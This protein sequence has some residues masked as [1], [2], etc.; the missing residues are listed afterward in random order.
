MTFTSIKA[1]KLMQGS[2]LKADLLD[3]GEEPIE[4]QADMLGGLASSGKS[5]VEAS[6]E[7]KSLERNPKE[8][9]LNSS[10]SIAKSRDFDRRDSEKSKQ[11]APQEDELELSGDEPESPFDELE[12]IHERKMRSQREAGEN[13]GS[14]A[15]NYRTDT[16]EEA[17]IGGSRVIPAETIRV[18]NRERE[19]ESKTR[20]AREF[21]NNVTSRRPIDLGEKGREAFKRKNLPSRKKR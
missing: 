13:G 17:K 18:E 10:R 15:E 7:E 12:K 4:E 21:E 2:K 20:T 16:G 14:W 3:S 6:L 5:N 1:K 8:R 19:P 9:S 11:E